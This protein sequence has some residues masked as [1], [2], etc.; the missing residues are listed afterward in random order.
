MA[1]IL[2][3]EVEVRDKFYEDLEIL[4][5]KIPYTDIQILFGGLNAR[6]GRDNNG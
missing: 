6:I 5:Q 3:A 4:I 2:Y 1:P